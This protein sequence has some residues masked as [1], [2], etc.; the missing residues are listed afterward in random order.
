M[1]RIT[2]GH[3]LFTILLFSQLSILPLKATDL[4][5]IQRRLVIG[6]Q[7]E[8]VDV[9]AQSVVPNR[10]ESFLK[11]NCSL[12]DRFH[13]ENWM[14]NPIDEL[15]TRAVNCE[16]FESDLP[17]RPFITAP[18][19]ATAGAPEPT[20]PFEWSIAGEC[21]STPTAIQGKSSEL[22]DWIWNKSGVFV[23]RQ[24]SNID[25]T[26]AWFGQTAKE[27]AVKIGESAQAVSYSVTNELVE[28]FKNPTRQP[29]TDSKIPLIRASHTRKIKDDDESA[30]DSVFDDENWKSPDSESEREQIKIDDSQDPYWQYYEDCDRWGGKFRVSSDASQR[31]QFLLR[32]LR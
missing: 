5:D 21:S 20:C 8:N 7:I 12:F 16:L 14:S 11:T 6:P 3:Y 1:A 13:S 15:P 9:D 17:P 31:H 25:Q 10:L 29:I 22:V 28:I 2:A 23:A 27:F 26:R 4:L 19:S 24:S 18:L 30:P 32:C